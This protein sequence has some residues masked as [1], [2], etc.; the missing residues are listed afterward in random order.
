MATNV[1][2]I[3]NTVNADDD[4]QTTPANFVVMDLVNDY[5]IWTEA[6]DINGNPVIID[7]EDEPTESELNEASTVID[8]SNSVEVA[9]CFVFDKDDGAG[10]IQKIDGMGENIRYSFGFSFDGATASEPQLE[11]WDDTNH[12]STD[13]HVLGN[14]TPA[15]SM[16]KVVCTTAG[17]PGS[18]WVGDALAGASN[19]LLLN[20][21]SGG[22]AELGSGIASQEVYYNL[23]IVIPAGYS[24]PAIEPFITTLRYLWN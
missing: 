23:K 16:L 18:A 12:D 22:L 24:T 5:L 8:A 20:N 9:K 15:D 11:A 1:N 4:Y 3:V 14:G 13:F 17:M 19:V 10:K 2:V 21:G 6:N 7:G